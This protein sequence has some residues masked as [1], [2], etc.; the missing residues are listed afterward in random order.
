[1]RLP[2]QDLM[3]QTYDV[4]WHFEVSERIKKSCTDP[5][6]NQSYERGIIMMFQGSVRV[7]FHRLEGKV[8]SVF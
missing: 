1:M 2:L 8:L 4:W 3:L 5:I 7:L 6:D